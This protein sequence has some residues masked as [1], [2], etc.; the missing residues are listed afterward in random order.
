MQY[1]KCDEEYERPS[2]ALRA[3]QKVAWHASQRYA[4]RFAGEDTG[5]P[6]SVAATSVAHAL[7]AGAH[8]QAASA[9]K[10]RNKSAATETDAHRGN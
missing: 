6:R 9:E 7:K 3:A 1:S 10:G 4:P 2:V 5:A 8:V